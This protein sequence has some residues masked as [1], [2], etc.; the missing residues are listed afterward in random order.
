[1]HSSLTA[2]ARF[3][4]VNESR[5][6]SVS[7][8]SRLFLFALPSTPILSQAAE[9]EVS[10]VQDVRKGIST[11]LHDP[12]L[13][14]TLLIAS[15]STIFLSGPMEAVLPLLI[16]QRF[17]EQVGLFGLLTTFAA[18]GS[19]GTAFWLGSF[20]RLRRRGPFTYGAWALAGLMVLVMG[21][22]LP[23][24]IICLAFFI[25]GAAFVAL[26]LAWMNTLQERVPSELL[27]RVTSIDY[28]VSS[29]LLPIGFGLAGIAAD[30]LGASTVFIL[31]GAIS[32]SLI[33][34]GFLHPDVR[35]VD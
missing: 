11:V 8:S 6:V 29:G 27:G 4:P 10:I 32:A 26:G 23:V 35:R 31:G 19:I 9:K 25:Q 12:W 17:G 1:M 33:A 20:K 16:K 3:W 22:P 30:R 28:L 13:W 14:L 7:A 34:L 18:F 15:V 21:L 24:V 2:P 5:E